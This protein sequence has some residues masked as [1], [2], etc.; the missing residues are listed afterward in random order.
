MKKKAK[1]M[2]SVLTT[3]LAGALA[4]TGCG[5]SENAST[6]GSSSGSQPSDSGKPDFTYA[7]S[8]LYKPF[9]FTENGELTGFDVE[10][11]KALAEKM[12]MNPK[13]VTNPFETII[14]GLQAKKYD[15]VIGSLT[16]NED[17]LKAVNFSDPYYR[18]GSQVFVQ[19][20]N[21]DIKTVDDIKGKKIGAQK[22]SIYLEIAKKMTDQDNITSYDS[23]IT[24]LLDLTTGRT[25]VVITDQ[26]VGLRFMKENPGK[27]K[28]VD[29]PMSY[30]EQAIA[31]RKEDTELL[32]K[33]NKALAEIIADGT[34]D[35]IS[36]KWFGRSILGEKQ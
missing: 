17:R 21:N 15:T 27:I 10:I 8:G 11:G 24:A 5:S 22:G 33:V 3:V 36:E 28:D 13:P 7:M 12:G 6:G 31:V 35:K 19:E 14:Q 29:K 26:M 1:W 16:I 32:E 23:D 4:L 20:S 30:D 2:I 18:S 34:Y 25:D 9:N